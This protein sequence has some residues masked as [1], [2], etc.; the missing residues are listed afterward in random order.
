[1]C[2]CVGHLLL[3]FWHSSK[4]STMFTGESAVELRNVT[5]LIAASSKSKSCGSQN[6]KIVVCMLATL[7]N[8]KEM[9]SDLLV[10][11]QTQKSVFTG[12]YLGFQ[13]PSDYKWKDTKSPNKIHKSS[14]MSG[15]S[16][17]F[18][19]W[20]QFTGCLFLFLFREKKDISIINWCRKENNVHQ[21]NSSNFRKK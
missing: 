7:L 2:S 9:L 13:S 11:S 3:L 20:G 12:T 5:W 10:S 8:P 6:K 18:Y 19:A 16:S 1:M 15:R 14:P 21:N 17:C 4:R